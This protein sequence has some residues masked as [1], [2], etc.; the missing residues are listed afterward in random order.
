MQIDREAIIDYL[1]EWAGKIPVSEMSERLKLSTVTIYKIAKENGIS[2]KIR[3]HKERIAIIK[4]SILEG[5]RDRTISDLSRE[6]DVAPSTIHYYGKM[7]GVSFMKKGRKIEDY[8]ILK[9]KIEKLKEEGKPIRKIIEELQTSY[10]TVKNALNGLGGSQ[11]EQPPRPGMF[12]YKERT[13][14]LI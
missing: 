1:R 9:T 3:N 5:Y 10:Y 12:N 7:L 8:T 11:R 6:H 4:K 2:V 14:W 13:N